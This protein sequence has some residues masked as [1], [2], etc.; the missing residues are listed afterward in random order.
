MPPVA[1]ASDP[2]Y[3]SASSDKSSA[4]PSPS[5]SGDHHAAH[6]LAKWA[7]AIITVLTVVAHEV[8]MTGARASSFAA[9]EKRLAVMEDWHA[10]HDVEHNVLIGRT[11]AI[12]MRASV[13]E[14]KTV[15][16]EQKLEE[17]AR[18]QTQ[19]NGNVLAVCIA[20]HAQCVR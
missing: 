13:A 3:A 1:R 4:P 20:T 18:A 2:G 19:T 17:F 9:D 14:S 6:K 10:A 11:S 8:Y 16:H 12:E 5:P 15:A 7:P